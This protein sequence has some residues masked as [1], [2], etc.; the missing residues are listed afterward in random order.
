MRSWQWCAHH[1]KPCRASRVL[2]GPPQGM[3]LHHPSM[4]VPVPPPFSPVL[5][6][7][8]TRDA[9]VLSERTHAASVPTANERLNIHAERF[10]LSCIATNIDPVYCCCVTCGQFSSFRPP[11]WT[12]VNILFFFLPL[13]ARKCT[14]QLEVVILKTLILIMPSM[15]KHMR[16]LFWAYSKCNAFHSWHRSFLQILKYSSRT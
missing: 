11:S 9:V 12:T 7:V 14:F 13:A 16:K 10:H 1:P 8:T 4:V 5:L 15:N 2:E 3:T 6:L